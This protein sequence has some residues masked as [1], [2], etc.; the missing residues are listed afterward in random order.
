M[1]EEHRSSLIRNRFLLECRLDALKDI[2]EKYSKLTT[3]YYLLTSDKTDKRPEILKEYFVNL[4]NFH[5]SSNS[6]AFLFPEKVDTRIQYHF[7]IHQAVAQEE[8]ILTHEHR[9]FG[10]FIFTDFDDLTNRALWEPTL[11]Q[12]S[13]KKGNGFEFVTGK[14]RKETFLANFENWKRAS[15]I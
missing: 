3:N 8:V 12:E 7:W 11:A 4:R 6:C 13:S 2:R 10:Y 9:P 14:N 5:A 1:L 15:G